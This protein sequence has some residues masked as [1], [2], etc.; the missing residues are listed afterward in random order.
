MKTKL[1]LAVLVIFL[2]AGLTA[3]CSLEK[4]AVNDVQ[5]THKIILP[6]YLKY[7]EEDPKLNEGQKD[8]RKKLV[9]SLERLV[10]SMRRSVD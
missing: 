4:K 10:E 2:V 7:V 8:D 5:A 9:E 1:A 6:Q 3:C